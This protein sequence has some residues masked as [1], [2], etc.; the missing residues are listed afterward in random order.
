MSQSPQRI[1]RKDD[2]N[3]SRVSGSIKVFFLNPR[4][5]I[6][7]DRIEPPDHIGSLTNPNDF[8]RAW[9]FRFHEV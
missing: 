1:S 6:L 4:R 3:V 8:R 2:L 5:L 7:Q 9:P